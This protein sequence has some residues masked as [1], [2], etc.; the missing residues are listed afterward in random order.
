MKIATSK[1]ALATFIEI[2]RPKVR[3]RVI[4]ARER[5]A[6]TNYVGLVAKYLLICR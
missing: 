5:I 6:G 4:L 1:K 2:S 3:I